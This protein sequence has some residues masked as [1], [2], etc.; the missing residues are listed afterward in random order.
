MTWTIKYLKSIQKDIRKIDKAEKKRIK[1]YLETQIA[2]SENPRNFG[3]VLKG[4]HSAF[5]WY[6]VGFYRIICEIDDRAV[7]I[8]TVRIGHRKDVYKI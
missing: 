6:R 2:Q 7:T 3:K 8:L 1:D 5:W 4:S